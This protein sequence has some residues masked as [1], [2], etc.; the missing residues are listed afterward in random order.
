VCLAAHIPVLS[1]FF[2]RPLN[3]RLPVYEKPFTLIQEVVLEAHSQ[4]QA[5]FRGKDSPTITGTLDCQA[6][7]D[8]ICFNPQSPCRSLGLSRFTR[9]L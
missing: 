2:F 8:K 7:D 4:A 1:D 6:C 3:E 5:A 9:S